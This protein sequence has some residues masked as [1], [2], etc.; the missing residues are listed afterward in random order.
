MMGG[1]VTVVLIVSY[2][3]G[4]NHLLFRVWRDK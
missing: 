4:L 3:L 1:V 2:I